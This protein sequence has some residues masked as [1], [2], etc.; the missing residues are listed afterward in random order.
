MLRN[1]DP[2]IHPHFYGQLMY[3]EGS[4]NIQIVYSKNSVGKI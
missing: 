2:E 4:K 3:D 1:R